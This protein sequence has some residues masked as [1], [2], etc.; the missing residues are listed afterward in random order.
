MAKAEKKEV[1]EVPIA[2]DWQYQE[3]LELQ[4]IIEISGTALRVIDENFNITRVNQTF[5]D[6]TGVSYNE[7]IGSKCYDALKSSGCH[8]PNCTLSRI[9]KGGEE[10]IK[11]EEEKNLMTVVEVLV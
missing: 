1:I 2:D 10:C 11:G 7:L 4:Q 5:A 8:T 6:L 9:L 3:L